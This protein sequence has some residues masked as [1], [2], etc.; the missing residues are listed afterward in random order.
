MIIRLDDIMW[1][2]IREATKPGKRLEAK[3]QGTG[4]DGGPS[5]A[6]VKPIG[7]WKVVGAE[8]EIEAGR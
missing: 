5:C 8:R 4:S 2:V 1:P 7:G 6:T 3:I